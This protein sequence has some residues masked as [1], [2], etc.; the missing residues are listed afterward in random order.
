MAARLW[1][2]TQH[3]ECTIGGFSMP[4]SYLAAVFAITSLVQG[5]LLLHRRYVHT[6]S[7]RPNLIPRFEAMTPRAIYSPP[8]TPRTSFAVTEAPEP[9]PLVF[10]V[11]I[12]YLSLPLSLP[13]S[14]LSLP[15]GCSHLS[16]FTSSSA[17]FLLDDSTLLYHRLFHPLSLPHF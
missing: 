2:I 17:S 5:P 9:D 7:I 12:L 3:V 1:C 8:S 15:F 11:I 16:C 14:H 4:G 10:R 13:I 6:D